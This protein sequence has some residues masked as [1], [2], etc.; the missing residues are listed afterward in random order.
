MS[1]TNCWEFKRCGR[2]PGGKNV[3]SL[4]ICPAATD[5]THTGINGGENAG[6]YCWK[7]E[8]TLCEAEVQG[9]WVGKMHRC[10]QCDFFVLVK[11]EEGDGTRY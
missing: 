1:K 5:S 4:G 3:A 7:V 6:R 11:S 8:G 10:L 2:E 9:A